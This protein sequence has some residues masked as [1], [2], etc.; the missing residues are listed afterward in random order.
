MRLPFS[1]SAILIVLAAIPAFADTATTFT[2]SGTPSTGHFVDVEANFIV[3]S[4]SLLVTLYNLTPNLAYD[5][6][7]LTGVSF[8][9]AGAGS[10]AGI[11]TNPI[12]NTYNVTDTTGAMSL[13]SSN[14]SANWGT[15]LS[16]ANYVTLT[17]IGVSGNNGGSL[18][19]LSSTLA[20]PSNNLSQHGPY[21]LTGAQFSIAGLGL[22]SSSQ[23]TGV[24]FGFG[25]AGTLLGGVISADISSV[26]EPATF[27]SSA[28]LLAAL[29]LLKLRRG[30]ARSC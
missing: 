10:N 1:T 19:M 9:F 30:K 27:A 13:A 3:S 11:L 28:L 23:I 21:I 6:Q 25:T 18:G 17:N 15:N 24:Q 7:I 2:Y 16:L 12:V 26:P 29:A 8:T 20:N 22:L 4:G 14:V 5:T